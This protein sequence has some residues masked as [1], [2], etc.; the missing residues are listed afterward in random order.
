MLP[1]HGTSGWMPSP[2]AYHA[3]KD[4]AGILRQTLAKKLEQNV[5]SHSDVCQVEQEVAQRAAAGRCNTAAI[6]RRSALLSR[7]GGR[8]FAVAVLMPPFKSGL[9]FLCTESERSTH[10]CGSSWLGLK[11]R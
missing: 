1:A 3:A 8:E 5:G 6:G 11:V 4:V 7:D 10:Q 9:S 2:R